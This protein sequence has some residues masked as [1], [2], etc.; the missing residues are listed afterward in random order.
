MRTGD[1]ELRKNFFVGLELVAR[2]SKHIVTNVQLLGRSA[3]LAFD[4]AVLIAL[5]M[6]A[7]CEPTVTIP[8][9]TFYADEIK[10]TEDTLGQKASEAQDL[11]YIAHMKEELK[12]CE[13]RAKVM[14]EFPGQ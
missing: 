10:N 14:S 6:I 1:E 11:E 3:K 4:A 7:G 13:A 9:C 12:Y 2:A 8:E 5:G